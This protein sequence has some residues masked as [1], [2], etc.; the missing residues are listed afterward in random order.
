MT[1]ARN[2]LC[3]ILILLAGCVA[4][5]VEYRGVDLNFVTKKGNRLKNPILNPS[6]IR[7]AP[8]PGAFGGGLSG[9][10]N[11]PVCKTNGNVVEVIK[12]ETPQWCWATS[13][14]TVMKFHGKSFEQ[15]GIVT[16][17]KVGG[18]PGPNGLPICCEDPDRIDCL[19]NGW[20]E[21][22]LEKFQFDFKTWLYSTW[23]PLTAEQ[24]AGQ[25][26]DN[27]PF[28]YIIRYPGGGGHA[29]TVRNI[30]KVGSQTMVDIFDHISG[31]FKAIPYQKF[32]DGWWNAAQ[33][34]HDSDIVQIEPLGTQ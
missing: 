11:D 2:F 14:Q 4:V 25:I 32:I 17:V 22:A 6:E 15:C 9:G 18:Q 27:G 5:E 33:Y 29:F 10:T 16:D 28:I 31:N 12:Q 23:G 26:C 8:I 20:P 19:K 3:A 13:A 21:N 30:Q 7:S 34:I 24:V 1:W